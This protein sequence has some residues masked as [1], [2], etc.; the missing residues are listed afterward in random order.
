MRNSITKIICDLKDCGKI[1]YLPDPPD[2][3]TE[4]IEE[5]LEVMSAEGQKLHFCGW[6]HLLKF[7]VE[8]LKATPPNEN[9][10]YVAMEEIESR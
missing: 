8:F 6:R 3:P 4:G 1:F 2:K 7:G 10:A 9:R 5:V